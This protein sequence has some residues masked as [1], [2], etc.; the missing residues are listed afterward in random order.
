MR[1][2][3]EGLRAVQ[4][5]AVAVAHGGGASARGVGACFRLR[6]RPAADPFAR[7]ELRD[8]AVPLLVGARLEDVVG[9]ERGVRGDDD[10]D[11]AVHA[12]KFLDD[13]GVVD[14][15][16]A[17][18]AQLFR[19]DRTQVAELAELFDHFERENLVFV[20]L[21]DVGPDFRVGE[22]ADGFTE[23][24]L[25]RREIEFHSL[26]SFA[27]TIASLRTSE[28]NLQISPTRLPALWKA[29]SARSSSSRVCVAV[30]MVRTRAFALRH[31]RESD[32]RGQHAFL[33]QGSR[34]LMGAFRLARHHRRD[35][36]LADARY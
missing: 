26:L 25:L 22:F 21:H 15:A 35:R 3:G 1:V 16:E 9:A 12:R 32:A 29:S 33:E 14:V 30:T 7:G 8:V 36:R 27:H 13:D 18:A 23:L 10:A 5:P 24:D 2:G 17:R 11:R 19:K 20:P 34:K 6:Q 31:G 28:C 4:Y